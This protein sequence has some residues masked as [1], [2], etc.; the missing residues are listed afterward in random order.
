MS[1]NLAVLLEVKTTHSSAV[2]SLHLSQCFT[3]PLKSIPA[4]F[5]FLTPPVPPRAKFTTNSSY[6]IPQRSLKLQKVLVVKNTTSKNIGDFVGPLWY[7]TKLFSLCQSFRRLPSLFQVRGHP[8]N[9][10]FANN[11][12][13]DSLSGERRCSSGY[14]R[15]PCRNS[16]ALLHFDKCA[17][18]GCLPA[19][20]A[21]CRLPFSNVCACCPCRRE[22]HT[23]V[24]LNFELF[25][26]QTCP[27]VV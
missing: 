14:R 2:R 20:E 16:E 1:S 18:H 19:L 10:K 23:P 8:R 13:C 17:C 21:P 5:S 27:R 12:E 15:E 9:E 3:P 4:S 26:S 7:T 24:L 6:K 11:V 25:A 22:Q